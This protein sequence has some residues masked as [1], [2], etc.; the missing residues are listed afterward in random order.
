MWVQSCCKAYR[1]RRKQW[2]LAPRKWAAM[3]RAFTLG[4]STQRTGWSPVSFTLSSSSVPVCVPDSCLN[5]AFSDYIRSTPPTSLLVHVRRLSVWMWFL[6]LK[7]HAWYPAMDNHA[8]WQHSGR[9]LVLYTEMHRSFHSLPTVIKPM[10]KILRL[11]LLNNCKCR[12]SSTDVAKFSTRKICCK[13]HLLSKLSLKW[14]QD[15]Q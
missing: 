10:I 9:T 5:S 8:L 7:T 15:K 12:Y 13:V 11:P 6:Q 1:E 2:K 3:G 14:P 4:A